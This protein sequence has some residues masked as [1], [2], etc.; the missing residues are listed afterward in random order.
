MTRFV[1]RT[2]YYKDILAYLTD[3]IGAGLI[4]TVVS[5]PGLLLGTCLLAWDI[6]V[7]IQGGAVTLVVCLMARNEILMFRIIKRLWEE[8][9]STS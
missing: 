5:I 8:D 6:W 4:V 7:S 1:L 3:C 9:G 2:G